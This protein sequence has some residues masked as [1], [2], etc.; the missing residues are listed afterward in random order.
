MTDKEPVEIAAIIFIMNKKIILWISQ[1]PIYHNHDKY[2]AFPYG[3]HHND[4]NKYM[5]F[6]KKNYKDIINIDTKI[7]FCYNSPVTIHSHLPIN[8]I[9]RH[10]IFNNVKNKRLPY[11]QYLNNIL[12]SKFTISTSGDRDDCYRHYE[13]I[14][15][16]SIPIS[17]INYKEIFE[18][19]MIYSNITDIIKIINDT[20]DLKNIYS[21]SYNDINRDILLIEYWRDKILLRVKNRKNASSENT[22]LPTF[23]PTHNSMMFFQIKR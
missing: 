13:C 14:G 18:N 17:D 4:I 11:N 7:K 2:M 21:N 8:H 16:N 23:I 10:N 9:R 3:I 15:L 19:N 1:N 6:I 22:S 20:G 12:K 5:E